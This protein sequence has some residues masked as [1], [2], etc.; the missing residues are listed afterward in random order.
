MALSFYPPSYRASQSDLTIS[1]CPLGSGRAGRR[2]V[3]GPRRPALALLAVL[4]ALPRPPLCAYRR[5]VGEPQF[6]V[7]LR[8][9]AVRL[10]HQLHLRPGRHLP[11]AAGHSGHHPRPPQAG[12]GAGQPQ[13]SCPVGDGPDRW[14]HRRLLRQGG[15]RGSL[16]RHD[17]AASTPVACA[18]CR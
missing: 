12:V 1:I 4:G 13:G 2:G 8:A 15:V 11:L 10:H 3:R 5:E 14:R 6:A 17:G 16:R 18:S 9:G 7:Q